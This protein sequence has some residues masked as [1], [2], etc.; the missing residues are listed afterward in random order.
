MTQTIEALKRKISTAAD[1]HSLV[2]TMKALAAVNIRQLEQAVDSLAE[3]N[4]TIELGMQVLLKQRPGAT[5][6]AR[7]APQ[8][9]LAAVV[10]GSDQGMCGQLNDQ[11]ASYTMDHLEQ[12][13]ISPKHRSI[14]AVGSRVTSRLEHAGQAVE[15]TFSVPSST[16]GITPLVQDLLLA[17]QRWHEDRQI[18]RVL[19]FHNEH[20]S[21]ASYRAKMVELLPLDRHWLD[22]LRQKKWPTHVLP[23][24]TMDPD[25]LFS[26]LVRHYLFVSLYR[27]TAESL[28]SE[29]ASRLAAMRGAEKNIG[30]RIDELTTQFHQQRQM[31]ITEELLDIASGFEAQSI[32]R[33]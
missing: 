15:T 17:I 33:Q 14:L 5:F 7:I 32:G 25:R 21:R 19:L 1:L 29:N 23:T 31:S 24:F 20:L 8:R 13:S 6:T 30:E 28:A 12:S 22:K 3:Y 16:A 26:D 27:A 4:R 10:F 9:R 18:D 2:K 11:I